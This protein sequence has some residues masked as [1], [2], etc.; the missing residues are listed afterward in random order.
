MNLLPVFKLRKLFLLVALLLTISF[1]FKI[2]VIQSQTSYTRLDF[3]DT[4]GDGTFKPK[5]SYASGNKPFEIVAGD[6]N[7]DGNQYLAITLY[8][9]NKVSI[10]LGNGNGSFQPNTSYTTGSGPQGIVLGDFNRDGN[11][12]LAVTSYWDNKLNIHLGNGDGTFQPKSS[13]LSGN[14]PFEKIVVGDFNAEV[15]IESVEMMSS[16]QKGDINGDETVDI[17]DVILC[18]R[19]AIGLDDPDLSLA[20]MNTDGVVDISDVI[21]ILRKAIGLD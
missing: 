13:F 20:D 16:L 15:V 1:I 4:D 10:H 18:L 11:Q 2:D 21:L 19:M 5:V 8:L 9:G 3:V 12:D 6:F 17:S 7:K 14:E